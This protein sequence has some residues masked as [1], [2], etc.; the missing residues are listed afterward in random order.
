M[1][2]RRPRSRNRSIGK[3]SDA[4]LHRARSRVIIV[5]NQTLTTHGY[6]E[7][8]AMQIEKSVFISYRH[9]NVYHAR[10]I[11]QDLRANGYDAFLDSESI[12]PGDFER[13]IL[14]QIKARAHFLVLLTPS[15]LERCDQ[16][17]DW[18]RREIEMA[19]D[20]K[21]NIVP[22]MFEGFD[23]NAVEAALTGK[24]TLLKNYN[25]LPIPAAYF[26]EAMARL[27]NKYLN[28]ALNVVLHP[29]PAADQNAVQQIVRNEATQPPVTEKQLTASEYFERAYEADERGDYDAAIQNLNEAIRLNSKNAYVNKGKYDQAIE[30]YDEAIRLDAK[31]ATAYNNRGIAYRNKGEYDQALSD[32]NEAIRLEPNY[33]LAYN[34]RGSIFNDHKKEFDNAIS[35]FT[36]CIN[37]HPDF[38][39]AYLNRAIAYDNKGE[40]DYAIADYTETLRLDPINVAAYSGRGVV[41]GKKGVYDIAIADFTKAIQLDPKFASAYNNRGEAHRHKGDYDAAIEDCNK[42]LQLDPLLAEAYES[43][44][45]AYRDKGDLKLARA[46]YEAALRINPN[47]KEARENLDKLNKEL[48]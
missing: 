14:G 38:L 9:T 31:L 36:K 6:I 16:P 3:T 17:G 35:D 29:T 2:A 37:L 25:G 23:F 12:G 26:D 18:L 4:T 33:V 42:A 28:I 15:A 10:A 1:S 40:Y 32:V 39:F 8:T 41:Y 11:F 21:R 47:Q 44:G 24:L 48:K 7:L 20:E 46:N 43:R 5:V 27:R 19:I 30:D 34:N 45:S 22:V 13:I